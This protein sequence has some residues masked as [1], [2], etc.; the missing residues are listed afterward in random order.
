MF[1]RFLNKI[2]SPIFYQ[3][4]KFCASHQVSVMVITIFIVIPLCYPAFDT[5]YLSSIKEDSSKS[6][7]WESP[8]SRT[9]ITEEIFAEKCGTK[10][11]LRVQQ[12]KISTTK[13]NKLQNVLEKDMLLWT[14]NLQEK[15]STTS[16][17]YP[18]N[19]VSPLISSSVLIEANNKN[20]PKK[21]PLPYTLS[22]LCF[23]PI[24]DNRCLIHSPLEYWSNNPQR[25]LKDHSIFNTISKANKTNSF[26]IPIPI[27]SVFGN[28]VYDK[29]TGKIISADSIILTYFFKDIGDDCNE[30]ET[31]AIWEMLW[32]KM[33][34]DDNHSHY[35]ENSRIKAIDISTSHDESK[36]LLYEEDVTICNYDYW[37]GEC[38]YFDKGCYFYFNGIRRLESVGNSI[39]KNVATR[40]LLLPLSCVINVDSLQEFCIFISVTMIIDYLLQMSLYITILSIDLRRLEISDLYNRKVITPITKSNNIRKLSVSVE[41]NSALLI[42]ASLTN[43]YKVKTDLLSLTFVSD[44]FGNST[45]PESNLNTTLWETST[46]TT[47]DK[48]WDI[49]NPQKSDQYFQFRPIKFIS[50]IQNFDSADTNN[51]S[52]N[53]QKSNNNET[54]STSTKYF[55]TPRVVT[56]RGCHSADVDLLCANS[57]NKIISTGIDKHITSWNGKQ[58]IPLKKLERYLRRCDT[59]K[60]K[61]TGGRKKCISWPVRAMCMSEQTD[62]AAAGFED[63]V[64]RV[65]D[66]N[67]GQAMFI[68][69]DTVEDVESLIN[70]MSSYSTKERVTCL[71]FI[72]SPSLPSYNSSSSSCDVVHTIFTHQKGGITYLCVVGEDEKQDYNHDKLVVLTGAR[73]GSVKCWA[74][75]IHYP[76][77]NEST[78]SNNHNNSND[79]SSS[80]P[81]K[82]R[83]D[84]LYTIPGRPNYAI[85]CIATKIIK[86]DS[87]GILVTGTSDGQVNV[88]DYRTSKL[89]VTLSKGLLAKQKSKKK[90]KKPTLQKHSLLQQQYHSIT[91]IIIHPLK[92]KSCP[93]GNTEEPG[94]FTIVTSSVDEKVLVWQLVRNVMDCT[95]IS[96]NFDYHLSN[97]KANKKNLSPSSITSVTNNINDNLT[98]FK[99]NVSNQLNNHQKVAE[100]N[101]V[102]SYQSKFIG[103]ISQLGGSAIVLARE[104]V[105]G[106][107]KVKNSKNKQCH[108][109]EGEWEVWMLDI[110][111][112]QAIESNNLCTG[113]NNDID[114]EDEDEEDDLVELSVQT[115]SLVNEKDLFEEQQKHKNE[116]L[117]LQEKASSVELKGFVRKHENDKNEILPFAYIRQVVK[118]GEEGVAVAYGNFIKVV[119]FEGSS[120][121]DELIDKDVS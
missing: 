73:D 11:P 32:K 35:R 111:E 47:T 28:P 60:C 94:G 53:N 79:S 75:N 34:E 52:N 71:K 118:V 100:W 80:Q 115:I 57:Y 92:E 45:V 74:R 102:V 72:A 8:S 3:H 86:K 68:L 78:P 88:Y 27:D 82:F 83:W 93:C 70:T 9:P 90:H 30:G 121:D 103:H 10:P 6:F 23:K 22:N 49:V 50:I 31:I 97:N 13:N 65:W 107:R 106:V 55:A 76:H 67:S 59:C 108:G 15:L 77:S 5:Y 16:I 63:G 19:T 33:A 24:N 66:L 7:F 101:G 64:V 48:F 104:H 87:I 29:R 44:F 2:L 43:A 20:N 98:R 81:H 51:Q 99:N 38:C 95:C 112:P 109:A 119:Y 116:Q 42:I 89:I 61:T 17:T 1:W 14:L 110:N 41:S 26:D 114:N 96:L 12:I 105:V 46:A 91:N 117:K 69:K 84:L 56:L 18:H 85:T 37:C 39:T 62:L 58:G 25:L 4:A 54:T 36:H 40:L 120:D 21:D 113:D